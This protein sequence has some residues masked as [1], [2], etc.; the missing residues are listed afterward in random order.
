MNANPLPGV[1]LVESPFFEELLATADLPA[2]TQ[3]I[4]RDLHRDGFAVFDFPEQDFTHLAGQIIDQLGPSMAIDAFRAGGANGLRLQD[5]WQQCAA[6]R[7]LAANKAVKA[8]LGDLYGRPAF[9]FQTLNFP[10][11][12]QQH[13]HT[14]SVHFSAMPERF[15]CGVWVALEDI[16]PDAGPLIYYPGSHR[17]PIYVNEHIGHCAATAPSRANQ[18]DFAPLW[19]ALIHTHR[20]EQVEFTP[21]RGQ[22]L[23]WAA[24]LLHGGSDH[25]DRNR[26]R[27]SQVTH[28]FFED[29][30]YYTPLESDPAF[31]RIFFRNVTDIATGQPVPNRYLGH[32]VPAD[33]IEATK[34]PPA[35][36][37]PEDFDAQ[38]YLLANPD[39]AAAGV[40]AG[41]H[42]LVHGSRENR[43]L[44]PG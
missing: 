13:A 9:P 31:G 23:I 12:S 38:L 40:D 17:L 10:F 22:A 11:G 14:D 3:R 37:L 32:D 5:A 8:L 27:W 21:R 30:A 18:A 44:R 26:T 2:E 33:Y 43:P 25:R 20:L 6:V 35:A 1:P 16:H 39:V 24:N 15:M 36:T 19:R 4:A 29:C 34:R 42:Y 7:S 41:E 28:Y